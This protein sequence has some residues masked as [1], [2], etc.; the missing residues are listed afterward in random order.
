[1]VILYTFVIL[2]VW[3]SSIA[4]FM[5]WDIQWELICTEFE[6]NTDH[7]QNKGAMKNEI[8]IISHFCASVLNLLS[9]TLLKRN[10][11]YRL[12]FTAHKSSTWS[13]NFAVLKC[14]AIYRYESWV[15]LLVRYV[16]QALV[17]DY[18][19]GHRSI[20]GI[21]CSIRVA[22]TLIFS[23]DTNVWS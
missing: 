22:V 10:S 2:L 7:H 3:D 12:E 6:V 13:I 9:Y 5:L 16:R 21:C 18:V 17:Y 15:F 11:Y 14:L 8:L 20:P 1:M 23:W 4:R 19:I